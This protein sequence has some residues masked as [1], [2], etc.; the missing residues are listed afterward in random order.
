M[1]KCLLQHNNHCQ[2]IKI[3]CTKSLHQIAKGI[4]SVTYENAAGEKIELEVNGHKILTEISKYEDIDLGIIYYA[5]TCNFVFK[6]VV[7]N[8]YSASDTLL[9]S[10]FNYTLPYPN[11]GFHIIAGPFKDTILPPVFS[12]TPIGT[13]QYQSLGNLTINYGYSVWKG[14]RNTADN[15]LMMENIYSDVPECNQGV[16]TIL[17]R[18]K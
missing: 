7:D 2:C 8:P 1:Q 12:F 15:R 13:R 3:H 11:N 5:P 6:V 9:I 4:F 14:P 16:D 18:I 17:V 10:D